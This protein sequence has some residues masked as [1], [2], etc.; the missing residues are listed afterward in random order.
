MPQ[1]RSIVFG[2]LFLSGL[3]VIAWLEYYPASPMLEVIG[4]PGPRANSGLQCGGFY[5]QTMVGRVRTRDMVCRARMNGDSWNSQEVSMDALNRRIV[6]ARR[7]WTT[8]DSG[9]WNRERDSVATALTL[10]GGHE[11]VCQTNN[12]GGPIPFREKGFWR[13]PKFYV[14]LVASRGDASLSQHRWVIQLDGYPTLPPECVNNAGKGFS[15]EEVCT[16]DAVIR[17]SLPG[18]RTLCVKTNFWP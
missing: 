2:S 10:R 14:R 17:M 13:F 8:P 11:F 6:N 3:L 7:I 9:Q 15:R 16:A 12:L 5:R 1:T 18:N 4:V